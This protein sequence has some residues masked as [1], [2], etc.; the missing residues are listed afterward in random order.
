M[1]ERNALVLGALL[2]DVGKLI[3]R[4]DDQP[5][6]MTHQEFGAEWLRGKGIPGS[7]ATIV[8][9][10]HLLKKADLKYEALDASVSRRTLIVAQA[11]WLSA[12]E[13]PVK[14]VLSDEKRGWRMD[15]PLLSVFSKIQFEQR[16]ISAYYIQPSPLSSKIFYPKLNITL[17][18][19]TYKKRLRDFEADFDT[20]KDTLMPDNVLVL[21]EKH[22]SCIPSETRIEEGRIESY[23]DIS[24]FDHL[25]TT[26][27]IA[28]VID[29]YLAENYPQ[30]YERDETLQDQIMEDNDP[31]FL[32]VGGDF[33]GVQRFIYT[34]SSRGALKTLR[35]RSF[36]LEL[37][38][39]HVV[40]EILGKIGLT[41]ANLVYSGGGRFY[42]LAPN[43]KT[44]ING[45]N[46]IQRG[47]NDWLLSEFGGKLY[48]AV[49]MVEFTGKDFQP[50]EI[51]KIWS[52]VGP[53]IAE[54]KSR[55]FKEQIGKLLEPQEPSLPLEVCCVCQ[56]D[57]VENLE[58]LRKEEPE[59]NRACPFCRCL[60]D[61]G[62]KLVGAKF[63]GSTKDLALAKN[64]SEY[65]VQIKTSTGGDL[66]Y[67][68]L[69]KREEGFDAL[70]VI[71]NWD[72]KE[73]RSPNSF[74]ILIGNY[75][76]KVGELPEHA[77]VSEMKEAT[78]SFEELASASRGVNRIGVLRMD[79]DRL[80]KIFISGFDQKLRTFSRLASLSRQLTLFF[81]HY[82]N[83]IC[84][85][86]LGEQIQPLDLSEKSPFANKGRNLCIVYSGGDDLFLVGA[87]DEITE[88]AFDIQRCFKRYTCDNPDVNISGGVVIQ[89]ENYPLYLLADLAREAEELAKEE[90]RNRITLFYNPVLRE[91]RSRTKNKIEQTFEWNKVDI[92]VLGFMGIFKDFAA[93]RAEENRL[94][95]KFAHRFLYRL[96]AIFEQWE[97]E[98]VMYLPT[99]A[100]TLQ[101]LQESLSREGETPEL[102]RLRSILMDREQIM[103]LRTPLIWFELLTRKGEK[104]TK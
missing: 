45:I 68:A 38:T 101:R 36:F 65:P 7:I 4:A 88:V 61:L 72:L 55:R 79:V 74:P 44:A 64:Y 31:K 28:N 66:H 33:S 58:P 63:I 76:R 99:M 77:R 54:A 39:E 82:I 92:K 50:G 52:Q 26:A 5:T 53:R 56:R 9:R 19:Q 80:G 75:V 87:W 49:G 24:L 14:E 83:S 86:D 27:A 89:K 20:I 62:D 57:D 93:L 59:E 67:V 25:K 35:S 78:A 42:I 70:Y 94:E 104:L 96:F 84:K 91:K 21:L 18:R 32:L 1:D 71:N 8:E 95:P 90:G 48:L 102:T 43:T 103:N 6:R 22:L 69:R 100:Y 98:G 51:S 12:A 15:I 29:L 46:K 16:P 60:F 85:A 40:A 17:D 11:D 73:Y 3:Q 30:Q 10:H 47:I 13:R 41:R 81:K 37:L 23:P 2:H 34:I 97:R